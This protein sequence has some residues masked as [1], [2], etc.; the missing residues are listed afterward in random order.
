MLEKL[1]LVMLEKSFFRMVYYYNINVK[2]LPLNMPGAY[3]PWH[4][5]RVKNIDY[6][7]Q[8]EL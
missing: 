8:R 2:F 5:C 1:N 4:K 7:K 3:S 6:L